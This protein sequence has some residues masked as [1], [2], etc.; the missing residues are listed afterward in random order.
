MARAELE[1]ADQPIEGI[2]PPATVA[3]TMSEREARALRTW[4]QALERM[5]GVAA[6][7]LLGGL[8]TSEAR[9]LL[10]VLE[11]VVP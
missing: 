1:Q 11:E 8:L 5:G 9:E 6:G 3:V 7:D 10:R 2:E 4:L